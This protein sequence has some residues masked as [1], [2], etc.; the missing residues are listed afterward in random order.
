[1]KSFRKETRNYFASTTS[2]VNS[3]AVTSDNKYIIYGSF[4][5]TI[6]ICNLLERR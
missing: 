5:N 1:M 4:V 6:R 2:Y 3:V